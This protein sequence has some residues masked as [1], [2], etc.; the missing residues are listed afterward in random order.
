MTK[1]KT[2]DPDPSPVALAFEQVGRAGMDPGRYSTALLAFHLRRHS[3][4]SPVSV[5][6][7]KRERLR[8]G[9]T[10]MELLRRGLEI[11][12]KSL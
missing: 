5:E 4:P 12:K 6:R 10:L 1:A 3:F 9:Q 8:G 11:L 7:A 2:A